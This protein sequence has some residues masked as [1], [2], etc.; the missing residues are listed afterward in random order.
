MFNGSNYAGVFNGSISEQRKYGGNKETITRLFFS[1]VSFK[2]AVGGAQ[3][4]LS[5][6]NKSENGN[7]KKVIT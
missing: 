7:L 6:V 1:L 5:N 4:L 3:F 2:F